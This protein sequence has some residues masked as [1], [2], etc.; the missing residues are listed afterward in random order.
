MPAK[1]PRLNSCAATDAHDIQQAPGRAPKPSVAEHGSSLHSIRDQKQRE[2]LPL[3]CTEDAKGRL[4]LGDQGV[5]EILAEVGTPAFLIDE[6]GL[7]ATAQHYLRAFQSR[8]AQVEVIYASKALPCPAIANLFSQEGLGCDVASFGELS[9][10]LA[11]GVPPARIVVHGNA[12]TDHYLEAALDARAGTIVID[13]LDELDRLERLV[14]TPVS[15]LVR[16]NPRVSVATHAAITTA[17]EASKFGVPSADVS[18]ALDRVRRHPL[19][20]LEGLHLHLGSQLFQLDAFREAVRELSRYD[21]MPTYDLGGG[22]G[23]RMTAADPEGPSIDEYAQAIV[24]AVHTYLGPDNR[25]IV[26]PGRSL[27]ARSVIS[28]YTVLSV[29]RT[30][31]RTFVAVDGGMGESLLARLTGAQFAPFLLDKSGEMESCDVVGPHCE[32]GDSLARQVS[33][34]EPSVGDILIVPVTGAYCPALANNFNAML[35]PPLVLCSRGSH[36]VV[37]RRETVDDLLDRHQVLAGP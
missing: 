1:D 31:S 35:R 13:A 7:R 15:V 12:K 6:N 24:T 27:V 33:L 2:L 16:V 29:K 4:C 3:T 36:R 37:A 14:R 30:G 21:A 32:N 23:V 26:E 8:H 5:R 18:A 25:L 20:R 10:A 17:D 34:S 19:L 22:L 11:A 28:A 9:M